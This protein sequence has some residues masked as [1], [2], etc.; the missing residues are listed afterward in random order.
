M[1][2]DIRFNTIRRG[3][4]YKENC[5]PLLIQICTVTLKGDSHSDR[6]RRKLLDSR[7]MGTMQMYR[8]TAPISF[9]KIKTVHK[10]VIDDR[11]IQYCSLH[12]AAV[13]SGY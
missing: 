2:G 9:L 6:I 8:G 1:T 5:G 13:T 7:H 12:L 3:R 10:S 4:F 11:N